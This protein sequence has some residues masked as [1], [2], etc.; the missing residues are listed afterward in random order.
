M[1]VAFAVVFV[2][3]FSLVCVTG[4]D[5]LLLLTFEVHPASTTISVSITVTKQRTK[6]RSFSIVLR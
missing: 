5:V 2:V 3:A 4:L 1:F 6:T